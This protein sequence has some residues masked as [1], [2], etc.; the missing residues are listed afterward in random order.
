[1]VFEDL[2]ALRPKVDEALKILGIR[3][4]LLGIHDTAFPGREDED[5]GCGTPYSRGAAQFLRFIRD[6]GFNGVQLGPQGITSAGNPSPYDGTFFSRSPLLLAPLRL[7][8][9]PLPLLDPDWF[10]GLIAGRPQD[11]GR[12]QRDFANHA[13]R[14]VTTEAGAGYRRKL[15]GDTT[16]EGRA[17]REAFARFRQRNA[18][19]LERDA[20]Y[21]VLRESYGGQNWAAW[22]GNGHAWLDRQLFTLRPETEQSARRR[23]R[24]LL[25]KYA[26]T[27]EDYSFTQFLIARQHRLLRRHCRRLGLNLFGDAQIGLSDRDSWSIQDFLLPGY[28]LGAPPSRTNPDGQP[29]NYPVLDPRHYELNG[30]CP[31]PAIRFLRARMDKL[32]AEFDGLRIDHPHGLIC[33][34]VYRADS[35]DSLRAVQSGARLFA[36]PALNDHPELAEYAI[37]R[38]GQINPRVARYDDAWVTD[39]DS[40][41]VLRYSRLFAAIVASAR[42]RR[43]SPRQIACEILS[44]QP[45]PIR[46]VMEQYQQGRFRVTQKADLDNPADVYR[47]ENAR[48][49]DWLMLGNHDTRPIWELADAWC[50]S[51]ASL[52]QAAYLADRLQIRAPGRAH[53][54]E[55]VANDPDLLVQAKFADLFVGPAHNV[56]VYFT[57]LFGM[58]QAYNRPGTVSSTNWS[59][60]VAADYPADYRKRIP[61][62]QVLNISAALAMALRA[63]GATCLDL[64]ATLDA[65]G[66]H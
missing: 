2:A 14:Q 16:A 65:F 38:P 20:L 23:Q 17:L 27:I 57:D 62:N 6:L 18:D 13:A 31:G 7:T 37:A 39:L 15:L 33:P 10:A 56:M 4:F 59:L 45:Y 58:H 49:E 53:W 36:S 40:D 30:G 43:H 52:Q 3:N 60:R 63:R 61:R 29:W 66:R 32:F 8:R 28:R 48:P 42:S 50:G 9:P 1:M 54:V 51:G 12:V 22:Q 35:A 25:E 55:R 21:E 26:V 64:I 46:R 41:Q 34:W 47:G 19:W 5:L 11:S 24:E 44:T